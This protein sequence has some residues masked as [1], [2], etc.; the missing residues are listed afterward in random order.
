VTKWKLFHRSKEEGNTEVTVAS[1]PKQKPEETPS[2]EEIKEEAGNQPI[3]EYNETLYS[4]GS[5]QKQPVTLSEKRQPQKRR[6][7][8]SAETIEHNVDH[9]RR[10]Q[11]ESSERSPER[12]DIDSKVDRIL[13]KKKGRL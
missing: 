1:E 3:K 9:I 6:S 8:E 4:K 11:I 10:S 7:W 12:N 5:V 2:R 13:L